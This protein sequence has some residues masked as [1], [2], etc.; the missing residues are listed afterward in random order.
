[1]LS[2]GPKGGQARSIEFAVVEVYSGNPKDRKGRAADVG[3]VFA[4]LYVPYP[5]PFGRRPSTMHLPSAPNSISRLRAPTPAHPW[6]VLVSSCM[7]GTLCA[8]DGGD[9]G[10]HGH[11]ALK[12]LLSDP[13][14]T[15]VPYCPEH[16]ALGTP[17]GIPDIHGGNGFDVLD[18]KATVL[19]DGA[20]DVTD[21]LRQH[22]LAMAKQ[23]ETCDF[24]MLVDMSAT[25]GSQVIS[26]GDRRATERRYQR[27]PALVAAALWRRQI[28]F[29]SHR[30]YATLSRLLQR[31]GRPA[32]EG[33]DHHE[34][35]WVVEHF[36]TE[37]WSRSAEVPSPSEREPLYKILTRAQWESRVDVVPSAPIDEQD[38]FLH[39][40]TESQLEET[41]RLHFG[42]QDNLI[43]VQLDGATLENLI[44]EPSRNGE[45]FPH[46]YGK[47]PLDRIV[48]TRAR[49]LGVGGKR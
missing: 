34:H 32:I 16:L 3:A 27:G 9:N 2:I 40:S 21:S 28:P 8:W 13:L 23:G 38:G 15:A 36:G 4:A 11:A 5:R 7:T 19:V 6:R 29:T 37:P 12:S 31:L 30:D 48:A 14:V 1:M 49:K 42:G 39:L 24:A 43:L 18:G 33:A 22:A 25:C 10:L 44:W 26:L 47:V 46:V 45:L 41:L 17:R 20:S 35:P